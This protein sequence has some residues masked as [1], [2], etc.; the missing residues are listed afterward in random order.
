MLRIFHLSKPWAP[1]SANYIW[2]ISE[3]IPACDNNTYFVDPLIFE[4]LWCLCSLLAI[5][6]TVLLFESP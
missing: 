3:I 6:F 1:K 5:A 2:P 4:S